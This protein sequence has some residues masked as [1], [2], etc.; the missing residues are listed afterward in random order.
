MRFSILEKLFLQNMRSNH[1][2]LNSILRSNQFFNGNFAMQ[3]VK[4][5]NTIVFILNQALLNNSVN[6]LQN[7]TIY[8]ILLWY[9]LNLET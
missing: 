3:P 1:Y 7:Y 2:F 9:S 4:F 5:R 6:S 8:Q